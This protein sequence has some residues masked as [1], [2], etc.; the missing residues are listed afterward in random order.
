MHTEAVGAHTPK[1]IMRQELSFGDT[2]V[3]LRQSRGA[4]S[5]LNPQILHALRFSGQR[6][7]S[8][9]DAID[10]EKGIMAGL[11]SH[12]FLQVIWRPQVA[13]IFWRVERV[14][15]FIGSRLTISKEVP[16]W[17]SFVVQ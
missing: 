7:K 1:F 6:L 5:H 4:E 17:C 12:F 11:T 9:D 15:W 16:R 14:T 2:V 13:H 3:F 10:F 8:W